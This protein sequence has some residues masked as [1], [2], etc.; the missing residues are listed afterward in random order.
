MVHRLVKRTTGVRMPATASNTSGIPRGR[1]IAL[2][3]P[4]TSCLPPANLSR[5]LAQCEPRARRSHRRL[6]GSE[7]PSQESPGCAI[8]D[9]EG[10][11]NG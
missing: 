8:D 3:P 11:K 10:D 6:M 4:A 2:C 5:W 9:R 1:W 7:R